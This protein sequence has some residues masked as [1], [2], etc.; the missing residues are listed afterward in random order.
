MLKHQGSQD[1]DFGG[2]H[3]LHLE[4][5][6][7]IHFGG[8]FLKDLLPSIKRYTCHGKQHFLD[9]IESEPFDGANHSS[10]YLLLH[11][12]KNVINAI[13]DASEQEEALISSFDT[14][15]ELVLITLMSQPHS[16]AVDAV[17]IAIIETLTPMRMTSCLQGFAGATIRQE[18]H[19]RGKQA[20][21][22]WGPI[23]RYG[24]PPVNAAHPPSR[25]KLRIPRPNPN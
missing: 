24:D 14:D 22:G 18:G 13:V 20:D 11:A 1:L 6:D 10:K 4:G 17:S 9:I 7:D 25:S 3:D 15:E 21:Y 12:R 16:E 8:G 19:P 5:D 23:D 2:G